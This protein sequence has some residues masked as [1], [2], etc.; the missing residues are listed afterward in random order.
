MS[1][2]VI[3]I[4]N[5]SDLA[6]TFTL[7]R[8]AGQFEEG[9]YVETATPVSLYGP[10][11]PSTNEDVL[12]VP[13]G[14]RVIGMFTFWCQQQIDH[15]SPVG[16]GDVVAWNGQNYKILAVKPWAQNGYYRAVGSRLSGE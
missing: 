1:I 12:M 14:D 13:E 10:V 15:T 16:T 5:D 11:Q 6:F 2:D 8:F 7:Q 3:D 9:G 4:V